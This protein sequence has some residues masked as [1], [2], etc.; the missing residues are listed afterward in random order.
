MTHP[1]E[2][3]FPL[4]RQIVGDGHLFLLK[5]HHDLMATAGISDGDWVIV[6]KQPDADAGDVVA[7]MLDGDAVLAYRGDLDDG[8]PVIGKV[9][10][11]LHHL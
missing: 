8:M 11:V 5:V 7:S 10:A 3:I 1:A 2:D 9:T 6:R 4:P